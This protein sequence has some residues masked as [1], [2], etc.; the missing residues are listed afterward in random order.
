MQ[1]SLGE[2]RP[3]AL[4]RAA[5]PCT[6]APELGGGTGGALLISYQAGFKNCNFVRNSATNGGAV[7]VG[8]SSSGIY[9]TDTTFEVGR[10]RAGGAAWPTRW[11][12]RPAG[13]LACCQKLSQALRS[14][15]DNTAT[16]F[17]NDVYMES[18]VETV[19]YFDPFP[20]TADVYSPGAVK[21]MSLMP[22]V[23]FL[24]P[25]PALPC[26]ALPCP[27][28][29]RACAQR[30]RP[31]AGPWMLGPRVL[32]GRPPAHPGPLAVRVAGQAA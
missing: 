6:A 9:F 26:P 28:Q 30:I 21:A 27:A 31:E 17:G 29:Q 14:P 12:P 3:S 24:L 16:T 10:G 20:T 7:G 2:A 5:P 32:A 8:G 22:P 11:A 18:W 1:R 23:S 15:Q 13:W 19:A 25:C 4:T